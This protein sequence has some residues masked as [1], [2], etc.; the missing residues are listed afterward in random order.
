MSYRA[1]GLAFLARRSAFK[2]MHGRLL[3][4]RIDVRGVGLRSLFG[5]RV[6]AL[7]LLNA[8]IVLLE[9]FFTV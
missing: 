9:E 8:G 2:R 1:R 5:G 3:L 7:G 4:E 6:R